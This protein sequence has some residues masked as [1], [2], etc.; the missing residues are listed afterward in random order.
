MEGLKP[1]GQVLRL[2]WTT[3]FSVESTLPDFSIAVPVLVVMSLIYFVLHV[4][5]EG[6]E[7]EG[8]VRLFCRQ[9]SGGFPGHDRPGPGRCGRS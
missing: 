8:A 6:Q 2:G 3:S 9:C 7:R 1:I 5:A 4:A